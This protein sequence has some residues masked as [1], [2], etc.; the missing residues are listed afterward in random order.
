LEDGHFDRHAFNKTLQ[1]LHHFIKLDVRFID[2]EDQVAIQLVDHQLPAVI[3]SV[4]RAY[5]ELQGI[6]QGLSSTSCFYYIN[7]VGLEYLAVG[8]WQEQT[9]C[10]FVLAGPFLSSIPNAD[11]ISDVIVKNNL[12]ISE[13]KQLQSFYQS[14][15][16]MSSIDSN[17]M[18]DFIVNLCAHPHA[19]SQL[20]SPAIIQTVLRK[21]EQE[22]QIAESISVIELRYRYEKEMMDAVTRGNIAE[23]RRIT[24]GIGSHFNLPDRI[25]ESPI[26]ST[27][28]LLITLNTLCRIAA[29][30]GGLH[31]V[32]VHN[33]SEK[34]S[35][36]IERSTNLPQL[37]KLTAV[38]IE[39]Y[40]EAVHVYSTKSY[41][42]IVKNAVNHIDLNLQKPLTLQQIAATIHVNASHLSRKF[43]QDVGINLIDYINLKRVEASKIY[44]L[45]GNIPITE[46]AFMVG[47]NDL[48]YFIRVFKKCTAMTPSQFV[49]E[50]L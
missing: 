4:G 21:E 46:I 34:F 22:S 16:F 26:R 13:R 6:V 28:N 9:Y 40:C 20:V 45:R 35:I 39:E 10:G 24:A 42:S 50:S 12:P 41:S 33:I 25:P 7:E 8:V 36:T 14:L 37:K 48:N 18:G 32:Y 5:P 11:F 15:S 38:I 3:Q 31:P 30:K 44:L 17:M 43:K 49:K 2:S 1:L 19:D 29:E 23:I 47:F 27:K